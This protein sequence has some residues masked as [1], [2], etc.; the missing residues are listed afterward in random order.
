MSTPRVT[1]YTSIQYSVRVLYSSFFRSNAYSQCSS[2]CLRDL[3]ESFQR[4]LGIQNVCFFP[5]ARSALYFS[6]KSLDLPSG[7]TV[8]ITP[9]T[10]TP[11]LHVLKSLGFHVVTVDLEPNTLFINISHLEEIYQKHKPSCLIATYLFGITPD[12][13]KL[14]LF[15]RSNKLKLIED[16]SQNIHPIS[17]HMVPGSIADITVYSCS[18]GKYLDSYGGG[19]AFTSN[20]ETF[21]RLLQ[22]SRNLS[23]PSASRIRALIVKN[24][25]WATA[26][27]R[28]VFNLLTFPLFQL[29]KIFFPATL[30]SLLGPQASQVLSGPL[31][32]HYFESFSTIQ[33]R[34]LLR[35][36]P[37]LANR[38]SQ[39]QIQARIV[40][41]SLFA[42][43]KP[44]FKPDY[45]RDFVEKYATR[46]TFW[47]F[48]LPV[49]D[50][51]LAQSVLFDQCQCE[52]GTTNLSDISSELESSNTFQEHWIKKN[53]IFIPLHQYLSARSYQRIFARLS[54]EQLIDEESC[55]NFYSL[56]STLTKKNTL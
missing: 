47:Q 54:E 27:N 1:L 7:S 28:Y 23:R 15:C 20:E 12:L 24:L 4:Q 18:L 21:Q 52:T 55:I 19:F 50:V 34:T 53:I 31:P 3:R 41:Y 43:L 49:K 45:L 32:K 26:L 14:A 6:L 29:L 51:Q 22:E 30:S 9:L 56:S 38:V 25:V 5:Y 8:V 42:I 48:P 35:Q 40:L 39:R 10:I 2:Q 44:H 37:L 11:Y 33:G 46:H 17:H 36:L 13:Q 16:V